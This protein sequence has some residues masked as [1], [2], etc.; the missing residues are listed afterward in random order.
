MYF[1]NASKYK[2]EVVRKPLPHG[3]IPYFYP[4]VG[5]KNHDLVEANKGGPTDATSPTKCNYGAWM[6]SFIDR[7]SILVA[8]NSRLSLFC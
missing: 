1:K 4:Y 5:D 6:P 7:W 2:S 3:S 8:S